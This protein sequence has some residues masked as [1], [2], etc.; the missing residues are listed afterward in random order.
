MLAALQ[1]A[2]GCT[3]Q[4]GVGQDSSKSNI[5]GQSQTV[6]TQRQNISV[7]DLLPWWTAWGETF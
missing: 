5:L 3:L 1:V 7:E 2:P 6:I 4:S